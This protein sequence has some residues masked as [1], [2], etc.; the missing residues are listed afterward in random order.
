MSNKAAPTKSPFYVIQEFLSPLKTE[1]IVDAM[2][3]Q[4]PDTDVDGFAIRNIRSNDVCEEM[5]YH[6]MQEHLPAIEEY[7]NIK[8]RGTERVMFEWYPHGCAKQE[9]RCENASYAKKPGQ[10][11][12]WVRN[13]DRDLS[14]VL[15]LSDFQSNI[16]FDTDY[17]VYG[18][19][20]EFPQHDF[21]F[22]PQRG[23]LIV[24]PSGP[25]FINTLTDIVYGDL[26][27]ARFHLAAQAP[28]LYDP[29]NFPGDYKTWLEQYA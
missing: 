28:F 21:G 8:Y 16:P 1:E 19:K 17:E 22:N 18:G 3:C 23:T 29:K 7:Y 20:L 9:P 12:G 10:K 5:I 15:F 13:R 14:C 27:M 6:T 25:H 11:G 26:F 4:E 2:D 24:F